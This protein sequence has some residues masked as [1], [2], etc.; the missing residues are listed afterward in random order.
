MTRIDFYFNVENKFVQVTE[1][2]HKALAKGRRLWV[3]VPDQAVA[4]QLEQA[5]STHLPTAFLPYCRSDHAL[6]SE[7]PIVIDWHGD[8]LLHDDVLMNLCLDTPEFFSR[9][10]GLI[11]L[12]GTEEADRVAARARFRFYRDRG[13]D[14]R[15]H[16]I[17]GG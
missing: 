14:I 9:F 12:V 15:A 6:A 7:T 4:E 16:D 17:G 1:L 8:P 10:Q 2:A 3:F 13:Y 11:E 5:L